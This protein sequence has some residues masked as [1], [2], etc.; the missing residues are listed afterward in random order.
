MSGSGE[1]DRYVAEE[2][3]PL[4]GR[5]FCSRMKSRIGHTS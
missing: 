2:A 5:L 3:F 1:F 4:I